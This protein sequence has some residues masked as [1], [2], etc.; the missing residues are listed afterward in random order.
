[1]TSCGYVAGRSAVRS[2]AGR[3]MRDVARPEYTGAANRTSNF[4]GYPQ[5][6]VIPHGHSQS[7]KTPDATRTARTARNGPAKVSDPN[8][9]KQIDGESIFTSRHEPRDAQ[10]AVVNQETCGMERPGVTLPALRGIRRNEL[11]NQFRMSAFLSSS[12]AAPAA[13]TWTSNPLGTNRVEFHMR[14]TR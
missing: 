3:N 11:A 14:Y 1:M 9:E 12:G 6:S 10:Q 2:S 4:P 5:T 13:V 8:G 7:R